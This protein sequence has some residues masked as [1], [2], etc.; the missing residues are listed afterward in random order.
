[1]RGVCLGVSRFW[2]KAVAALG[3]FLVAFSKI[4]RSST[5]LSPTRTP[6]TALHHQSPTRSLRSEVS[7]R[8]LQLPLPRS[9]PQLSTCPPNLSSVPS[10][11]D[12]VFCFLP[13]LVSNP[14]RIPGPESPEILASDFI[15]ILSSDTPPK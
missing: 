12:S 15:Q 14:N 9:T 1:M 8:S 2:K 3:A 13:L 7:P 6:F 11:Y 10:L 4:V 5:D